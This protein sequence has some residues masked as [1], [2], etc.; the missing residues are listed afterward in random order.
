[1]KSPRTVEVHKQGCI[2]QPRSL[3]ARTCCEPPL[4]PI[5]STLNVAQYASAF[6]PVMDNS[7]PHNLHSKPMFSANIG[8]RCPIGSEPMDIK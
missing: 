3:R 2:N 7:A 4:T 8:S 6:S 5:S 1:M